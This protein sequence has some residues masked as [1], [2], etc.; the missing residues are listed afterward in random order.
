MLVSRNKSLVVNGTSHVS[1]G[2][3]IV[4]LN[5]RMFNKNSSV[6][7]I[8]LEYWKEF[9]VNCGKSVTYESSLSSESHPNIA[10]HVQPVPWSIWS[11]ICEWLVNM[12]W[13]NTIRFTT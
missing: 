5:D 8:P 4:L 6:I 11:E 13:L 10:K 9:L 12:S 2:K 7:N 3:Q 1:K